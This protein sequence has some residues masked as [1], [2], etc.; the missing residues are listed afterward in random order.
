MGEHIADGRALVSERGGEG[1]VKCI[2]EAG[3]YEDC[4][5]WGGVGKGA[6]V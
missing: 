3:E 1:G 2:G 4:Y 5:Q 6:W